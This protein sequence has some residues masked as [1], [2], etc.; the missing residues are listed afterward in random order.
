MA[1]YNEWQISHLS[2]CY[3][4]ISSV[5][6]R[7]KT[8]STSQWHIQELQSVHYRFHTRR[9][10]SLTPPLPHLIMP[11]GM[12]WPVSMTTITVSHSYCAGTSQLS[13][14]QMKTCATP[15]FSVV[16]MAS[17]MTVQLYFLSVI[18]FSLLRVLQVTCLITPVSFLLITQ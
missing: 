18:M 12:G 16:P 2:P 10:T 14:C 6:S 4:E 15:Y 17:L 11:K 5:Q 13:Y 9:N 8:H 1:F 7:A 3:C